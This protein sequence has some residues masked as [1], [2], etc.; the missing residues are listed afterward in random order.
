MFLHRSTPR[1]IH[2]FP[3]F[4]PQI[5]RLERD[6]HFII[7]ALLYLESLLTHYDVLGLLQQLSGYCS[8]HVLA[9]NHSDG[10]SF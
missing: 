2:L 1:S 6:L 5:L 10:P 3:A 4:I 8:I 9:D 7:T